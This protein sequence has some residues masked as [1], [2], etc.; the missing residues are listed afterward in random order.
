LMFVF[1]HTEVS[2][3]SETNLP[4]AFV[5]SKDKYALLTSK[6]SVFHCETKTLNCAVRSKGVFLC[7]EGNI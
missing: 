4:D 1:T 7:K 6:P 5:C 3:E 2:A